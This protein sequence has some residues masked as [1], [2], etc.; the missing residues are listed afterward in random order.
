[1]EVDKSII[2]IF[3]ET[4]IP[5]NT[6]QI[7]TGI[8]IDYHNM[9]F[10]LTVAH[11]TDN[12]KNGKLLVP[13]I[14][15]LSEIEGYLSYSDLL[16][17]SFRKDDN[18]D[19]A[20]FRLNIDFAKKLCFRFFPLIE[21]T[22]VV[23]NSLELSSLSVIGYPASKTKKREQIFSSELASYRGIAAKE[24]LYIKHGLSTDINIILHFK[25]KH[26][27][28]PKTGKKKNPASPRGV[29][30]GAIFEW[31]NGYEMSQDWRIPK[32][33]GILHSY[34]EREGIFIGTNI[35]TYLAAIQLGAMKEFNN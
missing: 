32:L 16:P 27:L 29:S 18:L 22:K 13:T 6:I 14:H 34:K 7:G 17:D 26:S 11:V 12:L 8:F 24:E 9:P 19:I 30:G 33:V 5:K 15:G 21:K 1:M 23:R 3:L 35:V 25:I 10:I 28:D 2:P 20:Y 31:P 4:K